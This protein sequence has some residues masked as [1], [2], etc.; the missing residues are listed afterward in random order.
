MKN[1][2]IEPRM[3]KDD[4]FCPVYLN[5]FGNEIEAHRETLFNCLY[6]WLRQIDVVV[7]MLGDDAYAQYGFIT[8]GVLRSDYKYLEVLCD[9]IEKHIGEISVDEPARNEVSWDGLPIGVVFE[10]VKKKDS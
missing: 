10:P 1:E 3:I 5:K 4:E 7:D 8:K 2:R 9:L 6:N